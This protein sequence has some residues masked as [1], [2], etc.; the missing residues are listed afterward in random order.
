MKNRLK[1]ILIP[2]GSLVLLSSIYLIYY[3]FLDLS[4]VTPLKFDTQYC[5]FEVSVA[6]KYYGGFIGRDPEV[7]R[8]IPRN[9]RDYRPQ[10]LD[11]RLTNII[12]Y[13]VYG[14]RVPIVP[15][16]Y[17]GEVPFSVTIKYGRVNNSQILIKCTFTEYN[18]TD[19]IR[20]VQMESTDAKQN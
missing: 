17:H 11:R 15:A 10:E 12:I 8:R 20:A 3:S 14:D 2:T 5:N 13:N 19:G 18:E 9:N 4:H 16:S 1:Y 7:D 6:L